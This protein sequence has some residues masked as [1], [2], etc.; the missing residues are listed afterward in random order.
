MQMGM[1]FHSLYAPNSGLYI[2]QFQAVL[3]GTVDVE[4]LSCAWQSVIAKNAILRTAFFW[5]NLEKPL[6][7]TFKQ[8]DVS[9]REVDLTSKTEGE[10]ATELEE[11]LS[12]DLHS[13]F[14]L[15]HAPLMR[16][17]LIRLKDERNMFIWTHHHIL[18]DGWSVAQLFKEVF[19][20]Y[21][22]LVKE[23]EPVF[24]KR[25][26]FVDYIEWLQKNAAE[27]DGHFWHEYLS[28]FEMPNRLPGEIRT[29]LPV[30]PDACNFAVC[31]K[32]W[33]RE[34]TE[35]LIQCAKSHQLTLNT[36]IQGVWALAIHAY[37][38]DEDIV[39][40]VTV[41]GRPPSLSGIESMLGLFIN[42]LPLRV[43]I[44]RQSSVGEWLKT[45]QHQ[46]ISLHEYEHTPL[47]E[48]QKKSEVAKGPT[49]FESIVVYEN[50]PV[51]EIP[52]ASGH[53]L[54]IE[55]SQFEETTN[56][57]ITNSVAVSANRELTFQM[58]F[59]KHEIAESVCTAVMEYI[60]TLLDY[61]GNEGM[62]VP[63][64]HIPKVSA[65]VQE[66][67][68]E[69][70]AKTT[71]YSDDRCFHQLF[72]DAVNQT[73]DRTAIV[74]EEQTL[75]YRELNERA[76]RLARFLKQLG[77]Q[78][79]TLVGVHADRNV[80]LFISLLGILKAGGTFVPLDPAHPAERNGRVLEEGGITY[81]LVDSNDAVDASANCKV[82]N[83]SDLQIEQY[84]PDNFDEP[85]SASQLCYAIFTSGT[86][87]TPKGVLVTHSN[88]VNAAYAWLEEYRL[89][90]FDVKLLQLASCAFDV[91]MGDV[92]RTFVSGGTLIV[93]PN[94]VKLD[95]PRLYEWVD[96]HEITIVES[97]PA[98]L[99]P[100]MEYV[101][102]Q[103]LPMKS[104]QVLILGSDYLAAADY[105][106][107]IQR[108]GHH[109]RIINSY[110]VTEAT[111]DSS[112]FEIRS[113]EQWHESG[114][115]HVPIGKPMPNT[116]YYILDEQLRLV[117]IG[118]IGELY[119]GGRGISRGY[120]NRTELTQQSFVRD[121]FQ[122]DKRLYKTGDLARW[123]EDG[124]VEFLGREDHQ[125]KIRGYRVELGEIENA[126]LEHEA[127]VRAAVF[128][129]AEKSSLCAYVVC[130]KDTSRES[131][132]FDL[133]RRLP[134]YM[135]PHSIEFMETLPLTP[136]GKV[137]R[138]A[139]PTPGDERGAD[140]ESQLVEPLNDIEDQLLEV[141]KKLLGIQRIS[142][143]QS[144]F[145]LGGNSLL[146]LKLFNEINRL[147]P[148]AN[149]SVSDLF[150]Y[151]TIR[152]L[153][154]YIRS[155]HETDDLD[156]L[157]LQLE[158]GEIDL[159]AAQSKLQLISRQ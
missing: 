74:C 47:H 37:S 144:F 64:S 128:Y 141:W 142:T 151:H 95:L 148:N 33:S 98:L 5:E 125:I 80:S 145:D 81:L 36:I 119:I 50:Y 149:V 118:A 101:H 152:Q 143:D 17:H 134:E 9:I 70:A 69:Q 115:S 108:Y 132:L 40:G 126:L 137:D 67:Y 44:D 133:R 42:T 155:K 130:T 110:G 60:D 94:A 103:R 139:L 18:L 1:L 29:R 154:K 78:N 76:N 75:T 6:Q 112:Y 25:K 114:E 83:I 73:P 34:S 140:D 90:E 21:E 10:Q 26:P 31:E 79:E 100:F 147:F 49:L 116:Y 102:D 87:G 52:R 56:F 20:V 97:T 15:S 157:L 53:G 82:I 13:D 59:N 159:E 88:L 12:S 3:N 85:L 65:V 41:A 96:R 32:T 113:L 63:L 66:F 71:D 24:Q 84:A 105:K 93:C 58:K 158:K 35:K 62:G 43:R 124:I 77:V 72:E 123:R 45:I 99:V 39:F 16:F 11:L 8:V 89:S 27:D 104:L 92:A 122:P 14:I 127:I 146:I 150:S 57:K 106:Q 48:I 117:P 135:I 2:Q 23:E 28:G 153:S 30:Q 38:G 19:D 86:T 136:N 54:L 51:S 129:Y 46:M 111:V 91:F 138:K 22:A 131:V 121:P 107:L 61:F 156:L 4:K 7:V 68:L 109:M 120:L 55:R